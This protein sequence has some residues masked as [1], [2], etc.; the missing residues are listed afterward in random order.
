M[1]L[2]YL[3]SAM[4]FIFTSQIDRVITPKTLET[5]RDITKR[6]NEWYNYHE[7]GV[8]FNSYNEPQDGQYHVDYF[9]PYPIMADS[10]GLQMI[11]LG[12]NPTDEMR[13]KVYRNQAKYSKFSMCFDEIPLIVDGKSQFVNSENR[14]FDR[15][16]VDACTKQTALNIK[17]QID[18]FDELQTKC[19]PLMIIQ[20]NDFETYQEWTD[21][22]LKN[23]PDDYQKKIGGIAS[24]GGCIGNGELEDI[25]RYFT[26]GR[27]GAPDH[28]LKHFHLLGI[29]S[30]N[31]IQT[32]IKMKHLFGDDQLISYDSTKHT[33]G[34]VRSQ[35]QVG[36]QIWMI[37]R[38]RSIVYWKVW[39]L[40]NEFQQTKLDLNFSEEEFHDCIVLTSEE[41]IA[42]TGKAEDNVEAHCNLNLIR[43]SLMMFS[44]YNLFVMVDK[45]KNDETFV[46]K[47][48]RKY[49]GMYRTLSELHTI[50]DFNKWK[51]DFGRYFAS[52]RTK[53]VEDTDASLEDFF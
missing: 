46:S 39:E 25:E 43:F 14:K 45:L 31:R 50:S 26:L 44:V 16:M 48:K 49:E 8:L 17:K 7:F 15:S 21:K 42:K 4:S 35:I 12:H 29:G 34:I 13:E 23:I 20:G 32:L 51:Q 19:K 53:T 24:G 40:F 52:R 37:G 28:L 2:L 41:R 22:L 10:G 5:I 6:A 30:P 47:T 3:A 33:G 27:L 9:Y 18:I 11:T 38:G 1:Q 36:S